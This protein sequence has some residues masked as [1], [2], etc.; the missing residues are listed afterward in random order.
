MKRRLWKNIV[1]FAIFG[2][3]C[4]GLFSVSALESFAVST[5]TQTAIEKAEEEKERLREELSRQEE[6]KD[7]LN[8]Q[9]LTE[10]ERLKELKTQYQSLLWELDDLE[11]QQSEKEKEIR[12]SGAELEETLRLQKQQY[13]AMKQR[14][15]YLYETPQETLLGM[16]LKHS[17]IGEILNR[18][19]MARQLQKYD[20]DQMQDYK[21]TA[22]LLEEKNL[23]LKLAKEELEKLILT[24][25]EKQVEVSKLQQQAS[26]SILSYLEQ[27]VTA[28]EGIEDTEEAL[29]KKSQALQKLYEQ[30]QAEEEAENKRQAEETAKKLQ[31]AL[32]SGT[33]T[34]EDSGIVYGELQFTQAEMEML[35]AMIYCEARGESYEG[36]LAVGYVITNRIRSSKFPNDLE[37]ILRQGRQFEAAGSGRFDIVLTAYRENIPGM[38][39]QG[40][41]ESCERAAY[42]CVNGTSNVGECLFFR[43]HAPVPWLAENLEAAGVPYQ[44]IGN[45]IFYYSW[46]NY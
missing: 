34:T 39:G 40:E 17:G 42:E 24:A 29:E 16:I 38:I 23:E 5:S 25:R 8:D 37:S 33:I 3:A 9:K 12:N 21:K 15:C 28:Q 13:A 31:D 45:H 2:S 35:T 14:I 27:I 20:R 32:A 22:E 36:Q 44:I 41:W 26:E 19:D 46:V 18:I 10:E 30:A 43:T 6:E 7:T 11:E 4:A 1:Y